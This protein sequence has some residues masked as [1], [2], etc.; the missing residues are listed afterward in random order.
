MN[1]IILHGTLGN[2]NGNWFPWLSKELK[3]RGHKTVRPQLPTPNGQTMNNWVKVI[4]DAV[5]DIGGLDDS[6]IFIAHSMAPLA[7]CHYLTTIKHPVHSCFF[8][9]GFAKHLPTTPEPYP[10]LN[11]PLLDLPLDWN[12][13][14]NNCKHFTCFAGDND[15]YVLP[16]IASDFA[17]QLHA[18]LIIVPKGG[19]LSESSGYT[20]FPLL[21]TTIEEHI[22][23]KS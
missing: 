22:R 10:T 1:F 14:G 16:D 13:V 9:S 8:V 4:E 19:H 11:N 17:D 2:P 3:S 5:N 6:L 23:S 20:T 18:K 12:T 15:P 21:L 7:V